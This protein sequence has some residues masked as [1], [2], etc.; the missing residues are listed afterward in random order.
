MNETEVVDAQVVE[1][2]GHGREVVHVAQATPAT[3]FRTD[4]PV[5]GVQRMTAVA[6][7]LKG[8][9]DKQGLTKK[10]GAKEHVLVEGWTTC[11]ALIGV[12]PVPVWTHVLEGKAPD[13]KV[14]GYE[15]RV[16][17]RTLDGRVIGAAEAMCTRTESRWK[18]ADDYAIRSMAQ[19]RA[20]SKAL[21]GPLG[22]IVT[23]AGY[24][25]TPAEEIPAN[26]DGAEAPPPAPASRPPSLPPARVAELAAA[27][28]GLKLNYAQIDLILGGCGIE[29]L[30]LR[31]PEA[32]QARL[33]SLTEEQADKVSVE[34]ARRGGNG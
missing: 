8:I 21:R 12:T 9:L 13:G 29:A 23:L 18:T 5:E 2:N 11:G 17:A 24:E 34:L 32:L 20:T 10:I 6:D 15:A 14:F 19:T 31:T 7:A 26:G 16:E 25:A 27:I 28:G 30:A 33:A 1:E 4:D 3:L 22:F